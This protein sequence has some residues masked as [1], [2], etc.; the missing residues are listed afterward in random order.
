MLGLS[1]CTNLRLRH[2]ARSFSVYALL[3][4]DPCLEK[5]PFAR[6]LW[7]FLV[8][9][10]ARALDAPASGPVLAHC[11]VHCPYT[12]EDCV[13]E[14]VVF[15]IVNIVWIRSSSAVRLL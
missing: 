2:Y 5:K 10:S 13:E 6:A 1:V 9:H 4:I 12:I 14:A 8:I 15:F 11:D 7:T 3:L